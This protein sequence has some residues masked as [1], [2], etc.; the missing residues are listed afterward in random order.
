MLS[1]LSSLQALSI[2][3]FA[4]PALSAGVVPGIPV[5][6][7]PSNVS[8]ALDPRLVSFSFEPGFINEFL[9]NTTSPNKLILGLLSEIEKRTGALGFRPGG[10]TA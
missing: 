4:G 8:Q 9:G 2:I 3:L 10:I 7:P 6:P 5:G 1:T